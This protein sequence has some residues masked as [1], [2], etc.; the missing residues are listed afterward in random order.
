VPG[1]LAPG[2]VRG[3]TRRL[4]GAAPDCMIRDLGPSVV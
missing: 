3:A 1:R 4:R 2:R